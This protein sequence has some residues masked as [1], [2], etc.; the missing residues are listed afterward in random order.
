VPKRSEVTNE[1]E[2]D[3]PEKKKAPK[4][5]DTNGRMLLAVWCDYGLCVHVYGRDT[6]K[7][8]VTAVRLGRGL[9]THAHTRDVEAGF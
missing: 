6:T 3:T 5:R 7:A 8:T 1:N 9:P 2:N 4:N